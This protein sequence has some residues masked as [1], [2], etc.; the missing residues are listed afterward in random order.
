MTGKWGTMAHR[1]YTGGNPLIAQREGG[2]AYKKPE[3]EQLDANEILKILE[4]LK[5]RRSRKPRSS[6]KIKKVKP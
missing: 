5:P 1:I 4:P 6:N 2:I 3:F